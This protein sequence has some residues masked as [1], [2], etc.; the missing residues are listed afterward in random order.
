MFFEWLSPIEQTCT[1]FVNCPSI[2]IPITVNDSNNI[3]IC[4]RIVYHESF[5]I[6]LG[7][8]LFDHC[9]VTLSTWSIVFWCL[10]I[11]CHKLQLSWFGICYI[12][13][14]MANY[15]CLADNVLDM[16]KHNPNILQISPMLICATR[17][18]PFPIP[19]IDILKMKITF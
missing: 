19:S 4:L 8:P 12:K 7:K 5:E 9:V 11:A 15:C 13:Y 10:H 16:V 14:N 3:L 1:L 18:V 2:N 6:W 17:H